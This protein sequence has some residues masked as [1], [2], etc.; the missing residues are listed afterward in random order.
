MM[1]KLTTGALA[2][3][4]TMMI[5][6]SA[7]AQQERD[8]DRP[9][10][11]QRDGDRPRGERGPR[12]GDRPRGER[13]PRDGEGPRGERGPRD[14]NAPREGGRPGFGRGGFGGPGGPPEGR[15][16]FGM[17]PLLAALDADKDGKISSSEIEKAVAVLKQMDKNGDGNLTQ[18]ELRPMGPPEGR[19]GFGGGRP[20]F[21]GPPEGGRGPG[22]GGP[23]GGRGQG[24]GN[25]GPE[26]MIARV[27]QG[28]TNGDGKIQKDEA[29][30]P[31]QQGFD[32]ADTNS[33]G[34]LDKSELEA[35]AKRFAERMRNGGNRG[36]ERP[37]AG[38]GRGPE[39]EGGRPPRGPREGGE[40]K[41]PEVE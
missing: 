16:G 41:R 12:D 38:R 23:E 37:G 19:G 11:E 39:G 22:Q 5:V 9:R 27:M 32:N 2:A 24:R 4:M 40:R 36:G 34:S 25:F 6:G 33:D 31:L 15:G 3:A 26:Q 13:G 1:K 14:G 21:G 8:G 18:D 28:D 7:M 20:G 30:G 10:P 35:M 17:S 29:R